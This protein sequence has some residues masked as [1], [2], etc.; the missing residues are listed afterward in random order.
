MGASS[1]VNMRVAGIPA[2][3]RWVDPPLQLNFDLSLPLTN[4]YCLY[5]GQIFGATPAFDCIFPIRQAHCLAV[6]AIDLRMELHIRRE[7]HRL[8]RIDA[9]NPI[10][11]GQ[12]SHAPA[13]I[14]IAYS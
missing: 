7:P 1:G 8:Q 11:Q 14:R 9:V 12:R 4:S 3:F 13:A 6:G 5:L 10:L 2:P